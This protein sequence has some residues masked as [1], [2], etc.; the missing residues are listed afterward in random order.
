MIPTFEVDTTVQISLAKLAPPAVIVSSGSTIFNASHTPRD[1]LHDHRVTAAA[2]GQGRHC[3]APPFPKELLF[4]STPNISPVAHTYYSQGALR[5]GDHVAKFSLAPTSEAQLALV[6]RKVAAT[7]HPVSCA[8]GPTSTSQS[9]RPATSCACSCAP[10]WRRCQSRMPRS[11]GR[12]RRALPAGRHSRVR[13]AGVLQP[14]PQGVR[15]GRDEL[16][17]LVLPRRAPPA[18]LHQ[19]G[20]Q[21]GIRGAGPLAPRRQRDPGAGPCHARRGAELTI[22]AA[23]RTLRPRRAD[24]VLLL[25]PAA[26]RR[27]RGRGSADPY[28]RQVS[29]TWGSLPEGAAGG[30]DGTRPAPCLLGLWPT[31]PQYGRCA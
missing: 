19:P 20:T 26:A 24:C 6:D 4:D 25:R 2:T 23:D 7:T 27:R 5:Y 12:R 28:L 21:A 9:T 29:G 22:G 11:S 13:C 8:T 31:S 30:G 16:A 18:G 10:T 14:C 15:R 3:A 17:A 1:Q